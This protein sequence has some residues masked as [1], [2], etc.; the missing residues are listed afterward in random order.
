[1]SRRVFGRRFGLGGLLLIEAVALFLL[2][3]FAA[4]F[5]LG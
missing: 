4:S 1:M 2:D 5:F 3:A